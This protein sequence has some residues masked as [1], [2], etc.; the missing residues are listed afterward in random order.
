VNLLDVLKL[1]RR[2]WP[3]VLPIV[4]LTLLAGALM[5]ST[6]ANSY[7]SSASYF[8]TSEATDVSPQPLDPVVVAQLAP[9]LYGSG[10]ARA[11]VAESGF[12]D[13]FEVASVPNNPVI[14]FTVDAPSAD[15]AVG[16][17]EHLISAGPALLERAFETAGRSV[18]FA[19]VTPPDIADVSENDDGTYRLT[20]TVS[21]NQVATE[22]FNP[23]PPGIDTL[24]WMSTIAADP[25]LARQI[26]AVDPSATFTVAQSEGRRA[27]I[28]NTTVTA[29]SAELAYEIHELV[30]GRLE[31]ELEAL[32]TDAGVGPN[33]RTGF[34]SLL[35]PSEPVPTASSVVR[36]LAGVV[37]LGAGFALGSAIVADAFVMRR[38]MTSAK[39][40]KVG[41]APIVA[42]ASPPR[43]G[44][45]V[46]VESEEPAVVAAADAPRPPARRRARERAAPRRDD[47]GEAAADAATSPAR[48]RARERAAPRRDDGE[49]AARPVESN[50]D[51]GGEAAADAAT[52]PA[53]RRARERAESR[54]D[55]GEAAARPVES[56][57]NVAE[58]PAEE[59]ATQP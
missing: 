8:L 35:P 9:A 50:G 43:P 36:A 51:D 23:F 55:D 26:A 5:V 13:T 22:R 52:S 2:R 28:L 32:Q 37:V 15:L 19:M 29:S 46:T 17:V 27:P 6:R 57:G 56:N 1:V 4:L 20:S 41:A 14:R 25:A 12:V 54:R 49:A 44:A 48:R 7:T 53:R 31:G 34:G 39:R 21:V 3:V 40:T 45:R 33:V 11:S 18:A 38:R 47:G 10:L 58:L 42:E 30:I 16:T 59:P 24:D